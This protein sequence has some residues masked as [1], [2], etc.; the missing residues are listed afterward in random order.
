MTTPTKPGAL[1]SPN[2][3]SDT[4]AHPMAGAEEAEAA[5]RRA[6]IPPNTARAYRADL[7][8]FTAWCR[9]RGALP[10]PAS[11]ATLR[12]FLTERGTRDW[13][14]RRGKAGPDSPATLARRLSAICY[15]HRTQGHPSPW[16]D[17]SIQTLLKGLR[18]ERRLREKQAAPLL[19]EHLLK[20][21][22]TQRDQDRA[23]LLTGYAG[24]LRRSE[25]VGLDVEDV[26][27]LPED[28]AVTLTLRY[29]K[30]AEEERVTIEAGSGATCPV[31]ALK[32]WL[33]NATTGPV[34]H[35]SGRR[36]TGGYV[37]TLVQHA[38][39]AIGEPQWQRYSGHSL[40][41]GFATQ[42]ALN[43]TPLWVIRQQT[44]HKSDTMLLK[45]IRAAE[46]AQRGLT[47]KLGL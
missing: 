11:A 1:V 27:F 20:I 16:H 22:P 36:L 4:P 18:R 19:T 42:A 29:T 34:F 43:G 13:P 28:R 23:L 8:L 21:L 10:M 15:V 5:L 38:M 41:A 35:R 25:L 2:V 7:R 47:A 14:R 37:R 17:Q 45:Y 6:A 30:T 26:A 32:R 31:Q 39:R 24:A 12:A 9:V 33:G 40:R 44:R 46:A 3:L